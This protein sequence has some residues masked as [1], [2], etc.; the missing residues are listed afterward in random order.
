MASNMQMQSG[1]SIKIPDSGLHSIKKSQIII[2]LNELRII[3]KKR[4]PTNSLD[5]F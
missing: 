2:Q 3:I 4:K 5:T 1:V